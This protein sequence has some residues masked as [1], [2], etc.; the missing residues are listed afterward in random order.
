MNSTERT[1][2]KS[3]VPSRLPT[4]PYIT[5]QIG[6][7]GAGMCCMAIESAIRGLP[8]EETRNACCT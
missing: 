3:S 5:S 7:D 2:Q 4:L 6:T 8:S 1:G